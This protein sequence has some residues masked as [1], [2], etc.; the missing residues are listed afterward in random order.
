LVAIRRFKLDRANPRSMK[1]VWSFFNM[2]NVEPSKRIKY[3][4]ALLSVAWISGCALAGSSQSSPKAAVATNS[5]E[6][7]LP[8]DPIKANLLRNTPLFSSATATKPVCM[9]QRG[10]LIVSRFTKGRY[11]VELAANSRCDGVAQSGWVAASD[12]DYVDEALAPLLKRV[13]EAANVRIEMIYATDKIFCEGTVCKITE[14]LYGKARCYAAPAAAV[15]LQKAASTLA[16]R[17]PSMKLVLHDCYRPIDVQI[18]MFERINNATWVA[19][20]K[21]PRY[22]GHN[23]GVAIDLTIERDGKPLDMGSEFDSFSDKSNYDASKVSA[24]AHANRMLLRQL[25]IDAGFRPYDAEWWHFSLPVE[26]RAM[27]FPL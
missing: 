9:A 27:N 10:E 24:A 26:T 20:P 7:P 25:M 8:I 13:N 21:P 14:P 23:R 22:G 16:Q 15:A 3:F 1:N 11:A 6:S 2:H 17:D 4:V 12:V 19:R 18:E 5:A